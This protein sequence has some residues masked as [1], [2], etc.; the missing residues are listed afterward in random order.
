MTKTTI[1]L[2]YSHNSIFHH[3]IAFHTHDV[4]TTKSIS[5]NIDQLY[6]NSQVKVRQ[7]SLEYN[8]FSLHFAAV[9]VIIFCINRTGYNLVVVHIIST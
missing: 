4:Y 7:L 9:L 6:L 5:N 3:Y 2:L 1:I 8:T